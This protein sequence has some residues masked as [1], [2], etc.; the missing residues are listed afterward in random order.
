[1][2]ARCPGT[3]L[4]SLWSFSVCMFRFSCV[5]D[6]SDYS[7]ISSSIAMIVDIKHHFIQDLVEDKIVSLEFFL[8]EGQI[9]NNVTKPLDVSRFESLRSPIGLYTLY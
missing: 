5:H 7:L 4:L 3:H 8:M 2:V 9:A 1:M 6:H